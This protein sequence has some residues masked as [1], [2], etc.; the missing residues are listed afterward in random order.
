MAG[1]RAERQRRSRSS[2]THRTS[3]STSKQMWW[4]CRSGSKSAALHRW[5]YMHPYDSSRALNRCSNPHKSRDTLLETGRHPECS[6]RRWNATVGVLAA[7]ACRVIGVFKTVHVRRRHFRRGWLRPRN[8]RHR[9]PHPLRGST[10][11]RLC[12]ALRTLFP[13]GGG[14]TDGLVQAVPDHP[15]GSSLAPCGQTA[16]RFRLS[17]RR[18]RHDWEQTSSLRNWR[19]L[20]GNFQE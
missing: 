6:G 3:S 4:W 11:N 2:R 17:R 5:E 20:P 7:V 1:I 10:R 9:R 12:G 18:V 19:S 15:I 14:S 13:V 8:W 16:Q